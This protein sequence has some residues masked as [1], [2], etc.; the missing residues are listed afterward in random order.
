MFERISVSIVLF[1][2]H[3]EQFRGIVMMKFLSTDPDFLLSV[4]LEVEEKGTCIESVADLCYLAESVAALKEAMNSGASKDKTT[5]EAS[6]D[7]T[8]KP[9]TSTE[10][11]RQ[12]GNKEVKS[13]SSVTVRQS[14]S[15]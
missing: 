15:Y 3:T 5:A 14:V 9:R 2:S 11:V 6:S 1:C 10:A 8:N 12:A 13:Y 4:L 7:E